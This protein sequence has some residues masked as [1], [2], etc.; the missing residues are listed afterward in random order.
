MTA[1][2]EPSEPAQAPVE[3]NQAD[4]DADAPLPQ[5]ERSD[6]A[7]EH[8]APTS[9]RAMLAA[10]FGL[11]REPAVR[12]DP[13]ADLV[14]LVP[15]VAVIVG[16]LFRGAPP[17]AFTLALVLLLAVIAYAVALRVRFLGRLDEHEGVRQRPG[18]GSRP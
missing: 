18:R 2:D 13:R 17:S 9:Q 1:G 15:I 7:P 14:W 11:D 3:H 10:Y 4:R 16:L 5:I 12:P 6:A 8:P